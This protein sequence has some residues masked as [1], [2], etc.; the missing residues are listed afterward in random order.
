MKINKQGTDR[1]NKSL[2][3]RSIELCGLLF[4]MFIFL[5]LVLAIFIPDL[6]V[7]LFL[8]GVGTLFVTVIFIFSIIKEISNTK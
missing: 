5:V 7:R 1:E 4:F 2:I 3:R 6:R 8:F